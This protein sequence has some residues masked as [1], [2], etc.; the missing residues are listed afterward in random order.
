MVIIC[1]HAVEVNIVVNIVVKRGKGDM[2][3][4]HVSNGVAQ[5]VDI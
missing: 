2:L 1:N 5:H 4:R 3:E